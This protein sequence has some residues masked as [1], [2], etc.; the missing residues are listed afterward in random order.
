MREEYINRLSNVQTEMEKRSIQLQSLKESQ[1]KSLDFLNSNKTSLRDKAAELAERYE[2]LKDNNES[3]R[4][5]I[6]VILQRL[7]NNI[8]GLSDAELKMLRQLRDYQKRAKDFVNAFDQIRSK[9]NYQQQQMDV[10]KNSMKLKVQA[11]DQLDEN[12]LVSIKE[13]LKKDSEEISGLVQTISSAKR[14]L[15]SASM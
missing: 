9:R 6:E 2:D 13:V 11:G 7:N 10:I 15:A 8:S 4:S 3:Q 5:R 14:D 12:Q 1:F